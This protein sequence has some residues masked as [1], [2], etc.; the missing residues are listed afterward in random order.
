M[1]WSNMHKKN[2]TLDPPHTHA[3]NPKN[4]SCLFSNALGAFCLMHIKGQLV[5]QGFLEEWKTFSGTTE[6]HKG[7]TPHPVSTSCCRPSLTKKI[8]QLLVCLPFL[9]V[10]CQ[11]WPS[12]SPKSFW[13]GFLCNCCETPAHVLCTCCTLC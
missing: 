9:T 3:H 6:T 7:Y 1:L 10:L 12:N 5:G 8:S 4:C 11:L 13:S 2:I